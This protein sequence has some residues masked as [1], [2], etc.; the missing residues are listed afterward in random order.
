MKKSIVFALLFSL[1]AISPAL[2]ETTVKLNGV[3]LCCGGCVKGIEKAVSKLDGTSVECDRQAGTVVV[4]AGDDAAAKKALAA[5][6]RAGYYGTSENAKLKI[7]GRKA[8]D[9]KVT[10]QR[11]GGVHLCCGS[12]VKAVDRVVAKLDGASGHDAK[13]GA[14]TFT[15]K[16]NYSLAALQAAFQ[17]EGLNGRAV[18]EKGKG[19]KKSKK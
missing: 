19:K 14:K 18:R 13:K 17:A 7:P 16:G 5:I 9:T 1:A 12:C 10:D 15:V 11:V 8:K 2:A 4:K 3:H 6:G